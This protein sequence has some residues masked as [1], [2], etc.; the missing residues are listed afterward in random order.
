MEQAR[1]ELVISP[2]RTNRLLKIVTESA[3]APLEKTKPKEIEPSFEAL[4]IRDAEESVSG[5][6]QM[7]VEPA[8]VVAAVVAE[9]LE[10][11]ISEEQS[12]SIGQY[13]KFSQ[14]L[15]SPT[16]EVATI[17]DML[18]DL[19]VAD[20]NSVELEP[21]ERMEVD[22]EA[23]MQVPSSAERR[24]EAVEDMEA[25][26]SG[27]CA[28]MNGVAYHDDDEDEVE[29]EAPLQPVVVEPPSSRGYVAVVDVGEDDDLQQEQEMRPANRILFDNQFNDEFVVIENSPKSQLIQ[30]LDEADI[31]VLRDNDGG[32]EEYGDRPPSRP[33]SGGYLEKK[34]KLVKMSSV[35]HFERKSLSPQRVGKLSTS[36]SCISRAKS[37][38]ES[39]AGLGGVGS[40]SSAGP[41]SS[42]GTSANHIVSILKRKT[43]VESSTAASSASSNASPVT[44]SPSVVDTPIRSNR[45]QGILKKRCSLDESRYSRSHSPDD[46]SILVKHTRRN[47]F[48]D[49][50]SSNQQQQQQA[51]GILKQKSY[52]SREDVSG[53]AASG[54]TSRNSIASGSGSGVS[55]GPGANG[56]I[57]HGILKKK[58]DSSSTSTPSEPPKHVSIS[59]AV[60][61]AAAEICQDMLLVDEDEAYDIKPILKP[62]HQAP[63]TPKPILKKKYSS[64]NEEIRPILKSSRKSSREETSDSEEMKRSILKI[65]SPAKRTRCIVEQPAAGGGSSGD[66]LLGSLGSASSSEA[67]TPGALSLVHSRSLEHPDSVAPAPIVPQVTNIEKPIISV[68]ER[69]RNM[70]KFL[71][72]GSSGGGQSASTSAAV[73]SSTGSAISRRESF[74]YKTQPVT[75]TEINR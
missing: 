62:D 55:T 38:D 7:E 65:D 67:G 43:A 49:G 27:L 25:G 42:S 51:H 57:S 17:S 45:K 63:V 68:A 69:I 44:F 18:G 34:K 53:A 4:S 48:E 21:P 64:E 9:D 13:S 6:V 60:I 5:D 16:L 59:Q 3:G 28:A 33:S 23:E 31:I 71:S 24:Q 30:S 74:R 52:E 73:S 75:S 54:G 39:G 11:E 15:K 37:M 46:R 58:N 36:S 61:L 19:A 12:S 1:R 35:E 2:P 41:A 20:D 14:I 10:D 70:E 47:S 22:E 66:L 50:A 26:P 40:S 56:S 32:E 8:E 72:G 29:E